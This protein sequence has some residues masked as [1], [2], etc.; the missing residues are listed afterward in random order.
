M[1]TDLLVAIVE[2]G[3]H[4]LQNLAEVGLIVVLNGG[5]SQGSA[6]L[7]THQTTQASLTLDN[8]VGH[9]HLAA[10]GGQEEHQLETNRETQ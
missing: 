10:Q 2:V 6:G 9:T 1:T 3:L 5:Q 4:S 8:A 7:A